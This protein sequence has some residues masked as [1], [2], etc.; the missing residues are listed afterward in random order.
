[1]SAMPSKSKHIDAKRWY[2]YSAYE[3][4]ADI[5]FCLKASRVSTKYSVARMV[6][7]SANGERACQVPKG[8]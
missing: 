4:P 7:V 3:Y 6:E 8:A 2:K 5:K 1:M